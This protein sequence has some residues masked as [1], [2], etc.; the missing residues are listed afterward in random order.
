M[1]VL[2]AGVSGRPRT[3]Q[4]RHPRAGAGPAPSV[5]VRP[6]GA[7]ARLHSDRI[8]H[9]PARGRGPERIGRWRDAVGGRH[10]LVL[11]AEGPSIES[12]DAALY[13]LELG[14]SS[15][16]PH[17]LL[18][19]NAGSRPTARHAR[20][21]R[22]GTACGLCQLDVRRP[23]WRA[24][25]AVGRR[26]RAKR[27]SRPRC[28]D[29]RSGGRRPPCPGRTAAPR[30]ARVLRPP[31]R[32]R[33]GGRVGARAGA[34]VCWCEGSP[35]RRSGSSSGPVSTSTGRAQLTGPC[36]RRCSWASPGP[37][38]AGFVRRRPR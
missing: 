15:D 16:R 19:V 11:Q 5:G 20:R 8:A 6:R 35:Q 9:A 36:A 26:D 7:P 29:S 38:T 25:L 22:A 10:V 13:F 30:R 4:A 24:G 34:A 2:D 37:M 14:L 12:T 1:D 31:S 21:G 23:W 32:R 27:A 33:G 18:Q 28:R 17:V 3:V